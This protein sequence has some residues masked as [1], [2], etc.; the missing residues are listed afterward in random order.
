M[1]T[2]A[3]GQDAIAVQGK[4]Q[5]NDGGLLKVEGKDIFVAVI[6][7]AIGF[8]ATYITA[9]LKVQQDLKSQYNIAL[10]DKRIEAY[11]DLWEKLK[12][13]AFHSLNNQIEYVEVE[14]LSKELVNWYYGLGG[15]LLSESSQKKYTEFQDEIEEILDAK[16]SNSTYL[17]LGTS[18][19]IKEM[20]SSLR[21]HLIKDVGTREDLG[22]EYS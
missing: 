5:A 3:M 21:T 14:E 13:L 11:K 10:R 4:K 17:L 19:R 8:V 18:N 16:E 20:A 6:S 2:T 1:T 7:G 9:I 12:P 22:F 15:L